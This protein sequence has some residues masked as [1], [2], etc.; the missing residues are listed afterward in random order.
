MRSNKLFFL[1]FLVLYFIA[2]LS[3][4]ITGSVAHRHATQCK[5]NL[6]DWII[7]QLKFSVSV[8]T[9][10][11]LMSGAGFVIALGVIIIVLSAV[12]K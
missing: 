1:I 8:I 6:I 2:G 3:L 9:G 12:G 7:N 4:L 5:L 10:Y 11:S